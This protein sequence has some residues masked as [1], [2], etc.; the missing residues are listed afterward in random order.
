[1]PRQRP[2]SPGD[3]RRERIGAGRAHH[4]QRARH[5]HEPVGADRPACRRAAA[6]ATSGARTAASPRARAASATAAAGIARGDGRAGHDGGPRPGPAPRAWRSGPAPGACRSRRRCRRRR[7]TPRPRRGQRGLPATLCAPSRTTAAAA[8]DLQAPR[9]PHRAQGVLDHLGRQRGAEERLGG[10][11]GAGR[12]VALVGAV[13]R[14]ED[15]RVV[16]AR[17]PQVEEA[18]AHRHP[19]R[20]QSNSRPATHISAAPPPRPRPRRS[21]AAGVGLAHHDPAPRLDDA[22]PFRRR[23]PRGSGP[24]ISMWS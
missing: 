13:Q 14:E 8:D 15:L 21:R 10:G 7:R 12:V 20:L 16:A 19:A 3:G 6:L 18:P 1:M 5:Q 24:R 22:R 4:V 9:H 17:R 23:C 2:G 11:Q